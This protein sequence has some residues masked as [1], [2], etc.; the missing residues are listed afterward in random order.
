MIGKCVRFSVFLPKEYLFLKG[1]V[2]DKCRAVH[3]AHP[4][5]VVDFYLVVA[6]PN[7]LSSDDQG[8]LFLVLPSNI[9]H[10]LSP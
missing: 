8:R 10:V 5:L 7:S 2:L 9:S 6:D 1:S 4:N 3:P